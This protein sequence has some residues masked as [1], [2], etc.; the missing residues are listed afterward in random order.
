MERE[1]SLSAELAQVQEQ[2]G[3]HTFASDEGRCWAVTTHAPGNSGCTV[4]AGTPE[5]LRHEIAKVEHEWLR[6]AAV[7]GAA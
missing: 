1:P 4:D 6:A 7:R 5:L 2:T 3:W